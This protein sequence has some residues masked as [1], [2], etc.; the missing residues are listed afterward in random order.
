M[1]H[2]TKRRMKPILLKR[3]YEPPTPS[4]GFRVL[5]DRL[6]PRGV[7]QEDAAVDLWAKEIAPSVPLR[8]WFHH[9]PHARWTEF[10]E[11]YRQELADQDGFLQALR[12]RA[13]RTPVTLLFAAKDVDHTHALVVKRAL[14][15]Q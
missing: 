15:E 9:D 11:R 8:Q 4:D 6:W 3:I 2:G 14:E 10:C 1:N 7:K 5:V 13:G 12:L